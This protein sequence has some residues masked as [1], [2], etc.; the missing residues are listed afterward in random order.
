MPD[1]QQFINSINKK[2]G[3]NL[4]LYKEVQMKRRLTSLRDKRGFKDFSAYFTALDKDQTMMAEF[5]DKMTI[6]VSEFFRNK[7]RWDVL[8]KTIIPE[9]IKHNKKLKVWS[10]A[11]S[12][13]DEPYT[14]AMMLSQQMDLKNVEI[15]ATDIDDKILARAKEGIYT[16]R[17]LKEVPQALKDKY[18]THK[19]NLFYLDEKLKEA[20]TF[21]KHNLLN[22]P[23]PKGFD[24]IV[25]RNVMIYFTEE[26]KSEIYHKFSD[27][28]YDHGVFFVGS[29]EQIFNPERYHFKVL[30][31]F[32]YEKN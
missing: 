20:I 22:D 8:E 30:D 25:C 2:T 15:L 17:A 27:S 6:N 31:T 24:L 3:I 11:C 4:S 21:K 14:I 29:T 23:Y 18:F 32:F 19:D 28:L 12:T 16:E 10:A 1:Y 7:S 5:L 13:G 9:L 26:A